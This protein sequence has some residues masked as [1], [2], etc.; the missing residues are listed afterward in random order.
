MSNASGQIPWELVIRYVGRGQNPPAYSAETPMGNGLADSIEAAYGWALRQCSSGRFCNPHQFVYVHADGSRHVMR[1]G[2]TFNPNLHELMVTRRDAL[3]RVELP[4][5]LNLATGKS[6]FVNTQNQCSLFRNEQ[7]T[8]LIGTVAEYDGQTGS[9]YIRGVTPNMAPWTQQRNPWTVNAARPGRLL[10]QRDIHFRSAARGDT[11][12]I[13]FRLRIADHIGYDFMGAGNT[14]EQARDNLL[15]TIDTKIRENNELGALKLWILEDYRE[16]VLHFDRSNEEYV[17]ARKERYGNSTMPPIRAVEDNVMEYLSAEQTEREEQEARD[18]RDALQGALPPIPHSYTGH[19]PFRPQMTRNFTLPDDRQWQMR[20]NGEESLQVQGDSARMVC[21][22]LHRE[23]ANAKIGY[24]MNNLIPRANDCDRYIQLLQRFDIN[25]AMLEIESA[26]RRTGTMVATSLGGITETPQAMHDGQLVVDEPVRTFEQLPHV[27]LFQGN[28]R[29]GYDSERWTMEVDGF[30][31]PSQAEEARAA[32][33]NLLNHINERL[34]VETDPETRK[35]MRRMIT[36]VSQ[37][38]L[39]DYVDDDEPEVDENGRDADGYIHPGRV[40]QPRAVHDA[41]DPRPVE[42]IEHE[43]GD[44]RH[45]PA[46]MQIFAGGVWQD[47]NNIQKPPPRQSSGTPAPTG[48][49][50]LRVRRSI[51]T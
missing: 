7:F 15:D 32:R 46:G 4:G 30:P 21:N 28:R 45:T 23:I 51:S 49:K 17:V 18:R 11:R 14:L 35:R 34:Q 36:A 48:S 8:R 41:R 19:Y 20:I 42:E 16:Q 38:V 3:F 10:C 37:Y 12:V 47:V 25:A 43:E 5:G 31:Y 40:P 50:S 9:C 44:L 26:H 27:R 1:P 24:M 13:P 33:N 6:I 22:L 39:P 29:L 2:Q